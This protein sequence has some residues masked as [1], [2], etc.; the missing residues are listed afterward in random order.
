MGAALVVVAA[1]PAGLLSE[2]DGEHGALAGESG[3]AQRE[4][5]SFHA[6][7]PVVMVP[8]SSV[9]LRGSSGPAALG[10]PF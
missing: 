8:S 2:L 4:I 6:P 1:G 10:D 5:P 3:A 7:C 9:S